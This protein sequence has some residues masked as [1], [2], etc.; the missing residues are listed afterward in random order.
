M[1][2]SV[3]K[4]YFFKHPRFFVFFIL[5]IILGCLFWISLSVNFVFTSGFEYEFY[6]RLVILI[7]WI[8]YFIIS[9]LLSKNTT[10]PYISFLQNLLFYFVGNILGTAIY[11][12]LAVFSLVG[13]LIYS[14]SNLFV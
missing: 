7:I 8:I 14:L 13:W 4:Y 3:L 1:S 2:T 6:F 5:G 12:L 10:T 11:F 9:M